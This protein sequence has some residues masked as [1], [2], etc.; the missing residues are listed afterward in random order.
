MKQRSASPL[1]SKRRLIPLSNNVEQIV[2]GGRVDRFSNIATTFGGYFFQ[3]IDDGDFTWASVK[4]G[5]KMWFTAGTGTSGTGASDPAAVGDYQMATALAFFEDGGGTPKPNQHVDS[6]EED[7][8]RD[9][10]ILV[11][12]AL[13]TDDLIGEISELGIYMSN[14]YVQWNNPNTNRATYDLTDI[15]QAPQ[16]PTLIARVI[17]PPENRITKTAA[18]EITWRWTLKFTG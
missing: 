15:Y 16:R 4:S 3:D 12:K 6:Y 18:M 13:Q 14:T 2:T 8:A 7:A 17:V 5:T 10:L 1:L 9:E 11:F